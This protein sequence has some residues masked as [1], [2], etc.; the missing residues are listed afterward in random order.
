MSL[1]YYV[2]RGL[3]AI[4]TLKQ[5]EILCQAPIHTLFDYICGVS[6]G[7]LLAVLVGPMKMPL[8]R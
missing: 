5:I 6:T 8:D 3:V 1:G 4:E 2:F 7:G